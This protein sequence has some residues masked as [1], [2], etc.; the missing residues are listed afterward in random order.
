MP[1]LDL[2]ADR[3][4]NP[5]TQSSK[6][7]SDSHIPVQSP[8]PAQNIRRTDSGNTAFH[9]HTCPPHNRA[10]K[11]FL[12]L[13]L[14]EQALA[15]LRASCRDSPAYAPLRSSDAPI[16]I[17]ILHSPRLKRKWHVP[18]FLAAHPKFLR[19]IHFHSPGQ[20]SI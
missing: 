18:A 6:T 5:H 19:Y 12:L 8:T 11:E 14:P 16:R 15:D 1:L 7:A 3:S 4:A 17:L 20:R 2:A 13:P 10:A 9:S